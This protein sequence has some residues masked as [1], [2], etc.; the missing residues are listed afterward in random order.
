MS[1]ANEWMTPRGPKFLLKFGK[2]LLRRLVRHL[3][4]FLGVEVIEVAEELVEAVIGRQ[5]VVEIAEVVLAE[6][7]GGVALVP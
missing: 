5:H 6:L 1:V 2:V 3:G 7:P 4:L